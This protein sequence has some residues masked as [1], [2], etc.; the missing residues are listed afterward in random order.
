MNKKQRKKRREW[1][2]AERKDPFKKDK[3]RA[4]DIKYRKKR[5]NRWKVAINKMYKNKS[6]LFVCQICARPLILF[7]GNRR[8]SVCFDHRKEKTNIHMQPCGWLRSRSSTKKNIKIFKREEFGILC[9]GCNTM[10][11]TKNRKRWLNK[12]ID[13]IQKQ[14][15]P[16]H[17]A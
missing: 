1:R 12:V 4:R 8:T 10:I 14:R 11:P 13:Y 17:R 2:R 15:V 6:G 7:S 3:I 5:E 9:V 16:W